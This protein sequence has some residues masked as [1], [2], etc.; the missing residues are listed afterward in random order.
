MKTDREIR[1]EQKT[2]FKATTVRYFEDV[3]RIKKEIALVDSYVRSISEMTVEEV[4]AANEQQRLARLDALKEL[5]WN[6]SISELIVMGNTTNF[7][8]RTAQVDFFKVEL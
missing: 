8:E 7:R 2:E 3:T 5:G 1:R 6:A 4:T